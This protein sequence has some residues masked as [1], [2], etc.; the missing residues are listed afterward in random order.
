MFEALKAVVTT[1]GDCLF[2]AAIFVYS[3]GVV[4]GFIAG[5]NEQPIIG[6]ALDDRI[7]GFDFVDMPGVQAV[8]IIRMIRREVNLKIVGHK[9]PGSYRRVYQERTKIIF[10]RQPACPESAQRTSDQIHGLRQ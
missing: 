8:A 3:L 5:L 1:L 10:F 4:E 9:L 6:M 2:A 7:A